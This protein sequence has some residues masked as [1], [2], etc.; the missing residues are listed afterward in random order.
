MSSTPSPA[1]FPGIP[2][3]RQHQWL[4]LLELLAVVSFSCAVQ[5]RSGPLGL[6]DKLRSACQRRDAG[7][8]MLDTD[9]GYLD[10]L[11]G[12]G[13][14]EDDLR[15]LFTVYGQLDVRWQDERLQED[16]LESHL[17]ISGRRFRFSG[18]QVITLQEVAGNW[19]ITSGLLEVPRGILDTLRERRL[20]LE[21]SD[22]GRLRRVI[23][24]DYQGPGGSRKQLLQRLESDLEHGPQ[25]ALVVNDLV[26]EAGRQRAT[27]IQSYLL[28]LGVGDRKKQIKGREKIQLLYQA[29]RWRIAGGLG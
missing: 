18:P 11:G 19:L 13:R 1:R 15:Q 24:E 22:L 17:Q 4:V 2:V 25:R 26:I 9:P 16:R 6:L 21:E 14:L 20:G 29:S 12:R 10:T 7:A 3:S 8:I 5:Q 23:S 27:V 28:I